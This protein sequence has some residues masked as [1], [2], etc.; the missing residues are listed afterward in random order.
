MF[1]ICAIAGIYDYGG[2][3]VVRIGL[4][5]D[6]W[7]AHIV[8]NNWQIYYGLLV[9]VCELVVVIVVPMTMHF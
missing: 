9:V 3:C 7:Y 8:L 2:H 1:K 5:C 6:E 4:V